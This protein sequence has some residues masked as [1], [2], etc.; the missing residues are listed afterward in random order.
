M[1][2]VSLNFDDAAPVSLTQAQLVPGICRPTAFNADEPFPPA[3]PPGP[4]PA[5]LAVFNGRLPNGLWSLYVIDDVA[6]D[7]GAFADGWSLTIT[8]ASAGAAA[9]STHPNSGMPSAPRL[10][11]F[12]TSGVSLPL[13][14]IESMAAQVHLICAHAGEHFV[15]ESTTDFVRW[16]ALFTN[17]EQKGVMEFVE[18]VR[19]DDL[20]KFYRVRKPAG[21]LST[22]R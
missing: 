11:S 12:L 13:L 1:R 5:S 14:G 18:P 8:T 15:L 17:T 16:Q 4:Y 2:N 9:M 20:R 21:P 3:A 22:N 10:T 7:S 6:A 19:M